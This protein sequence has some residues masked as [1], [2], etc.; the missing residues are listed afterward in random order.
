M[1]TE[2]FV[3]AVELAYSKEQSDATWLR[4]L[5]EQLS[6]ELDAGLGVF[7]WFYDASNLSEIKI[8]Y[9]TLLGTPSGALEALHAS[10]THESRDP[11]FLAQ[12]YATPVGTI[13]DQLRDNLSSYRPLNELLVPLGIRDILTLNAFDVDGKGVAI[14]A[15]L[16]TPTASIPER[17]QQLEQVTAHLI[18][19]GRLRR[20][21]GAVE[22]ILDVNGGVQHADGTAAEPASREALSFAARAVEAARGKLRE[23]DPILALEAWRAMVDGRWSVV[24]FLD[25]DGKRFLIARVNEPVLPSGA[26]GLSTR[27]HQIAALVGRGH[28]NKL[29][30]Y[31]LGLGEGTVAGYVSRVLQKLGLATRAEV[32]QLFAAREVGHAAQEAPPSN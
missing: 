26:R 23:S 1:G 5:I 2:E 8:M 18:S 12:H 15:F 28:S 13:S 10:L 16:P 14:N 25:S 29:I 32:I 19:G 7:G 4:R 6:P 9:P 30:A 17:Q 21:A 31:D 24:D 27:E 3:G 22:A 20:V 11:E